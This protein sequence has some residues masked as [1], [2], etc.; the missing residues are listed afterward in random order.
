MIG[1]VKAVVKNNS[2]I[3]HFMNGLNSTSGSCVIGFTYSII[4]ALASSD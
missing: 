3:L 1:Q 2:K 4:K